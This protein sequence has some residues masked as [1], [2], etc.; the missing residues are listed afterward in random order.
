MPRFALYVSGA[1]STAFTHVSFTELKN[2]SMRPQ[3]R[4]AFRP[5]VPKVVKCSI[6][7][8]GLEAAIRRIADQ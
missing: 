2:V 3:R 1:E 7:K 6:G 8:F 5:L 4:S